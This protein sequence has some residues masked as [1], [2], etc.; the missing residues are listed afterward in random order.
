M[1]PLVADEGYERIRAAL[2]SGRSLIA[3]LISL[4]SITHTVGDGD[5][6]QELATTLYERIEENLTALTPTGQPITVTLDDRS[7]PT[8]DIPTPDT[9][10]AAQDT[11]SDDEPDAEPEQGTGPSNH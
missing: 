9:P 3:L 6:D 4:R 8:P 5:G 11:P 10:A 2:L 1:P 7:I